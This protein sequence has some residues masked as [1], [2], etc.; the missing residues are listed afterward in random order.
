MHVSFS[1]RTILH[2]NLISDK[3]CLLLL[4]RA[5]TALAPGHRAFPLGNAKAL[6]R[7]LRTNSDENNHGRC[8]AKSCLVPVWAFPLSSWS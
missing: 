5:K 1:V 3:L 2:F 6:V 4:E 8:V 7:R